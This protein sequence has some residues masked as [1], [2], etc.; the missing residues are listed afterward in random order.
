MLAPR[1]I[2]CPRQAVGRP[3]GVERMRGAASQGR[4]IGM[5][6]VRAT[7]TPRGSRAIKGH[8]PAECMGRGLTAQAH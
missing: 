2:M 5:N 3:G 8:Y 4:K 1:P 7:P 6:Y